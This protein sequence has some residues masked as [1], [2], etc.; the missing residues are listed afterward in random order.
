MPLRTSLS[1]PSPPAATIVSKPS[2]TAALASSRA[3]P[4]CVVGL[5]VA[6]APSASS[7]LR[8]LR[9]LSPLAVGLKITQVRMRILAHQTQAAGDWQLNSIA[10]EYRAE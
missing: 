1:V 5:K 9:A 7:C 4:A 8:K 10:R 3:A 6:S 2:S